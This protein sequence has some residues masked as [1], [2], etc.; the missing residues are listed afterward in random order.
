MKKFSNYARMSKTD[1]IY[2][3]LLLKIIPLTFYLHS[4]ALGYHDG[5]MGVGWRLTVAFKM[6]QPVA[7]TH[8][9]S[10]IQQIFY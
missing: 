3:H 10:F 7:S 1:L 4:K 8:L 9:C 2:S 5:N 6:A